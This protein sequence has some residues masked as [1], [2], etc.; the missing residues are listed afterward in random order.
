[1]TNPSDAPETPS[2]TS[3]RLTE[4]VQDRVDAAAACR[5][6]KDT[7]SEQQALRRVFREMGRSQRAARR[8]TGQP[9]SPVV[10]KAA[11]AFQQAPSFA[12]L[13]LV[14][15]SLDEVGLLSW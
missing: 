3:R 8:S 4:L 2:A 7:P 10:R 14:A 5:P 6:T 13:V 15:A 9:P 12:S 1:M 11:R